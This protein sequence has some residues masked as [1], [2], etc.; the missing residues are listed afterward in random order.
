MREAFDAEL[1]RFRDQLAALAKDTKDAMTR[2]TTALLDNSLAEAAGVV[3]DD[4][5][6]VGLHHRIDQQALVLLARQQPVAGDLRTIM[7][8]LRMSADLKRMATLARHIAE[9]VT[10]RHPRP[11]V[12]SEVR[13]TVVAMGAVA[14]RLA[15]AAQD[16]VTTENVD[17][18][19]A[20]ER[21]DDV[22]DDLL[23]SLYRTLVVDHRWDVETAM[24]LTL[25]GRYYERFA[26]H[27]VSVAK[28]V[29]FAAGT[30]RPEAAPSS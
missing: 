23:T 11:V 25:L 17:A 6:L 8:G 22:M 16:A 7:A 28:R 20:L 29:A 12:P 5:E 2:A 21:A 18:A 10:R 13:Q 15:G 1:A 19:T 4:D 9:L 27:A 26:D 24:D 3:G 14:V 30:R